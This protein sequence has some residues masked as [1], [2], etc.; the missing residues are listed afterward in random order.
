MSFNKKK[1]SKFKNITTTLKKRSLKS[2]KNFEKHDFKM[3]K[4]D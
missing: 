1:C 2:I 4:A 3:R